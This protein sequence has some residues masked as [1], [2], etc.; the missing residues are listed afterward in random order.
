MVLVRKGVSD[1][2]LRYSLTGMRIAGYDISLWKWCAAWYCL[3]VTTLPAASSSCARAPPAVRRGR[4]A[5][6]GP[7]SGFA[8]ANLRSAGQAPR[9]N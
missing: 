1:L 5:L 9:S 7:G 4:A 2:A 3:D 6:Y 8:G